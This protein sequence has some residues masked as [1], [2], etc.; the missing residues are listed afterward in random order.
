MNLF[1]F[2]ELAIGV[3]ILALIIFKVII[4]AIQNRKTFT[5]SKLETKLKEEIKAQ[6]QKAHEAR[7]KRKLN[8]KTPT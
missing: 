6:N 5:E 3:G 2:F 7:L 1:T 4:P 8:K